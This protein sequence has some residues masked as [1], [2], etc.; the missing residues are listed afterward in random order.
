MFEDM[1]SG[2]QKL[3]KTRVPTVEVLKIKWRKAGDYY[4]CFLIL[5]P[6]SL[7]NR[8]WTFRKS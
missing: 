3:G 4:N 7:I 5:T 2:K 8:R 1:N 6:S